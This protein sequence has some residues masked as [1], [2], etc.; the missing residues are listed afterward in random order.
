[1]KDFFR[2]KKNYSQVPER[3][4]YVFELDSDYHFFI[5]VINSSYVCIQYRELK[6][7]HAFY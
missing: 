5:G 3:T 4:L 1:M 7:I 6:L 2:I